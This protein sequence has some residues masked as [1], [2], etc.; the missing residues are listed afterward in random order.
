MLKTFGAC[1]YEIDDPDLAVENILEQLDLEHNLLRHSLGIISCHQ[2][3]LHSGAVRDLCVKLPFEVIGSTTVISAI[4]GNRDLILLSLFVLTSEDISFSTL[5][6]ESLEENHETRIAEAYNGIVAKLPEKPSLI[7]GFL[8][9]LSHLGGETLVNAIT[10]ASG[11]VPLFGS[12]ACDETPDFHE[13]YTIHNG[14]HFRDRLALAFLSGP[15]NQKFLICS[16]SAD[17]IHKQ[18]AIITDSEGALLKEINDTP[19]MQ[20]LEGLGLTKNNVLEQGA[21]LTPLIVDYNDGSQPL[22]RGIYKITPEGVVCGG[23]MPKGASFA[24]GIMDTESVLSSADNILAEILETG[25]T[26]GAIL[27]CCITRSLVLGETPLAEAEK[28]DACLRDK[29]PYLLFYSGG[30]VCPVYDSG[31]KTMNR[32]HNFTFTVCLF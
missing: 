32:F 23:G 29:F 12:I 10:R 17:K 4:N 8:P 5:L 3:Y 11:G 31:G 20:Y 6:T 22:A 16:I 18:Q 24:L 19:A 13:S 9:M 2:D 15:V 7:L 26:S 1:T 27:S 25:K 28:T 14:G 30:E 21:L